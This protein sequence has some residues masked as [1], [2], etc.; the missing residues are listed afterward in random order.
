LKKKKK[1]PNKRGLIGTGAD[2]INL[3]FGPQKFSGVLDNNNIMDIISA[4]KAQAKIWD[5]FLVLLK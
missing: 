5:T 1:F 3:Y 4:V 2:L